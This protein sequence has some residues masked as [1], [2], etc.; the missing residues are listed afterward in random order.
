M[1]AYHFAL[2]RYV[3]H[4]AAGEFGNIGVV[5]WVPEKRQLLFRVS[6]RYSRF[7]RFFADFDGAGYRQVA[8]DL[9]SRL[10]AQAERI[11]TVDGLEDVL[12]ALVPT[13]S[14][15]FAASALMGGLVPNPE[16]RLE[17]LF[18]DFVGKYEGSTPR[19]RHDEA[20]IMARLDSFLSERKLADQVR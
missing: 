11:A 13:D 14:S 1:I 6:E 2:L 7:S 5:M 16:E 20:A 8:R 18:Y 4:A 3:H 15:C 12:N 17:Q 10:K 9:H 19:E